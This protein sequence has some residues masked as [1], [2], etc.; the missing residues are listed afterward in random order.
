MKRNVYVYFILFFIRLMFIRKTKT[1]IE[2]R[3]IYGYSWY[4]KFKAYIK[5]QPLYLKFSLF[6]LY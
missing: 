5:S 6:Y 2:I 4:S 3:F 1:K